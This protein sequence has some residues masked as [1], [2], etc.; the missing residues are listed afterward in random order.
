[1]LQTS[2]LPKTEIRH[3]CPGCQRS[4]PFMMDARPNLREVRDVSPSQRK[5]DDEQAHPGAHKSRQI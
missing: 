4:L 5:G 1:M 2:E 3:V